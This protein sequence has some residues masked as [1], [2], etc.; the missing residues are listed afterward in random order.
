MAHAEP[1]ML[2]AT[3]DLRLKLYILGA[4]M[5]VAMVV[6]A[7]IGELLG[8]WNDLGIVL[9]LLGVAVT[10]AVGLPAASRFQ[11]REVGGELQGVAGGVDR[12]QRTSDRIDAN[13]Q[14][15]QG[16]TEAIPGIKADTSQTVAL[17][18]EIRDRLPPR[19]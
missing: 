9:G 13:T 14:H 5:G 6:V 19:A 17:L 15:I 3:F 16:N 10:L 1:R 8:W 7:A 12:L 11:V 18:R 4:A 2:V